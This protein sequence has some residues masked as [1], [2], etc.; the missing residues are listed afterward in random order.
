MTDRYH[1]VNTRLVVRASKPYRVENEWSGMPLDRALFSRRFL[2]RTSRKYNLAARN[3]ELINNVRDDDARRFSSGA[4]A[5]GTRFHVVNTRY[6]KPTYKSLAYPR[7]P[8]I[9]CARTN[10]G[11]RGGERRR[12]LINPI[13]VRRIGPGIV[14]SLVPVYAY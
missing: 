6:I 14:P 11:L 2:C 4:P 8:A 1:I 12:L 5:T 10:S 7:P 3:Y 13:I 9:P